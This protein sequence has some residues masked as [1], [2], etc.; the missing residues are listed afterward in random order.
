M[1]RPGRGHAAPTRR[2]GY[3][4]SAGSPLGRRGARTRDRIKATAAELFSSTGFHSTSIDDIARAIGGSRAT[5]Y[6]YFKNKDQI[7]AEMLRDC[8]QAVLDHVR[9][10]GPLGPGDSGRDAL[11]RWLNGWSDIYDTYAAVFLEFPAIGA[12]ESVPVGDAARLAAGLREIHQVLATKLA[13]A[14]VASLDPLVASSVLTRTAHMVNLY[15]HRGMFD[16]PDRETTTKTLAATLQR[17]FFPDNSSDI[18]ISMRPDQTSRDLATES[19]GRASLRTSPVREDVLTVSSALF[20]ERG[21]HRVGMD[22]IAEQVG[23]SRATLYRHFNSKA[24][25]LAELTD[26]AAE[27][28]CRLAD[29]LRALAEEGGDLDRLYDWTV[30]FVVIHRQFHGV[31]RAWFDGAVIEEL[32]DTHIRRGI[33]ALRGAAEAVVAQLDLPDDVDATVATGIILAALGR[34]TEPIDSAPDD[35]EFAAGLILLIL[36]RG[37]LQFARPLRQS[38]RPVLQSLRRG[39]RQPTESARHTT[40]GRASPPPQHR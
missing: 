40:R 23:I 21:Y 13:Q 5:V 4:A 11:R 31:T 3:A 27:Q 36:R 28:T 29:E 22:S 16:M 39:P 26:M 35:P 19:P 14:G 18:E 17:I 20:A 33:D 37:L 12:I 7:F 2:P 10:L 8:T 30:R 24:H 32:G 9:D 1:T 34:L 15:R 6:Q 25:I 38:N